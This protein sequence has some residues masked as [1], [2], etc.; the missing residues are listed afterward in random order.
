MLRCRVAVIKAEVTLTHKLE[1]LGVLAL[2]RHCKLA[3]T[4]LKLAAGQHLE[5]VGIDAV[6]EI[7][8]LSV[9]LGIAEQI[10]IESDLCVNCG[11]GI[12]PVNGRALDLA[13]V[14]RISAAALGVGRS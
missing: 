5:T 14:G 11:G 9:R 1:A 7:L 4:G 6:K 8:V 10:V 12:D 3:E 2:F 13:P